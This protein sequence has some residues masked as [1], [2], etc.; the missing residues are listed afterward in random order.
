MRELRD[1]F[2]ILRDRSLHYLDTAATSQHPECVLDAVRNYY[3]TANANPHRGVYELAQRATDASD[4]ARAAAARFLGCDDRELVFTR[5]ATES[6]NLVA[7]TWGRVNV[8]AG[9]EIAVYVAE[10][11]SNMVPWQRLALEKGAAVRYMYPDEHGRLTEAELRRVINEKTRLVALAQVSNV[12]GLL[13]PVEKAIELAHQVGAVVML[14]CAQS[15][16]HMPL[17]LHELGCDFAALS[18]HKLYAPMGIGLLYGRFE[19]LDAMPPFLSGGDMISSVHE[20]GAAWADVP[21][22]FEA[23]TV[24]VGGQVGLRAAIEYM[25]KLGWEA[26]TKHEAHLMELCLEGMAAIPGITVYGDA[27][28]RERYGV[29]SFNVEDVHPHDVASILDADGV[30]IRAGHHCAQPLMDRLGIGRCC[31]ASFGVYNTEEDVRSFLGS[32][33]NVRSFMGYGS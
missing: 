17:N 15:A 26:I 16:P 27:D 7:Y 6:I 19:L 30:C 18:G 25:E 2:P 20:Y 3:E 14:D 12:L 23:G 24:D 8:A 22:K 9:D 29:I 13:A 4:E 1:D 10:H 5:N 28:P 21:R 32:L 31:R 33:K 11:H